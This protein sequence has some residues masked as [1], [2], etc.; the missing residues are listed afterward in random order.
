MEIEKVKAQSLSDGTKYFG[1]G[2][3]KDGDFIPHGFGKK[4]CL[5]VMPWVHSLMVFL[6]DLRL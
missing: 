6:M 2:Y 5:I 1:E 4:N 3:F